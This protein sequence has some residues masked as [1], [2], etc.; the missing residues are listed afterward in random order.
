M[1]VDASNGSVALHNFQYLCPSFATIL[2]NTYGSPAALFVDGDVL[3]S[4]EGTTQGDPLA[5]PFYALATIPL[6][7]R[8]C[9]SVTQAWY[10]D[11]ASACGSLGNLRLW[12]NQV[13]QLGPQF[14]YFPNS[15]KM[16]LVVKEQFL[17]VACQLFSDTSVISRLMAGLAWEPLLGLK[18][19]LL[20]TSPAKF[21]L[22]PVN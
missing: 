11:D 9:I 5:M 13:S 6:I 17:D 19:M 15:K 21:P 7:Q 20:I 22:G 16:W 3:Y 2:I 8:L 1:L 4:N 10:A 12:W 18:L 14:G